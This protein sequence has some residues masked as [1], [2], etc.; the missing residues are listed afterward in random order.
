MNIIIIIIII[1]SLK[2]PYN[3]NNIFILNVFF[4]GNVISDVISIKRY[5]LFI[6]TINSFH[7]NTDFDINNIFYVYYY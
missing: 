3:T 4:S 7:E 1:F 5:I 2:V 6:F